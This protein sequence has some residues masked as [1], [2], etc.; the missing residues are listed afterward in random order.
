MY[1]PC[2]LSEFSFY[3]FDDQCKWDVND[4]QKWYDRSSNCQTKPASNFSWNYWRLIEIKPIHT[5]WIGIWMTKRPG[6]TSDNGFIQKLTRVSLTGTFHDLLAKL[7]ICCYGSTTTFIV[8]N[9]ILK[10][11]LNGLMYFEL[12]FYFAFKSKQKWNQQII[13]KKKF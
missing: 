2:S 13:N 4:F 10:P 8:K 11:K 9:A 3:E 12:W 1:I 6:V 5:A 7:R